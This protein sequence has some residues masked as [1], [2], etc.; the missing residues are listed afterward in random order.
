MKGKMIIFAK[1]REGFDFL[2]MIIFWLIFVSF[3]SPFLKNEIENEIKMSKVPN[4]DKTN[5]IMS[6]WDDREVETM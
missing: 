1:A 5:L 2:R 3:W 4:I 6:G